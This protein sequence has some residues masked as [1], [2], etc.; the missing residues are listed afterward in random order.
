MAC[1]LSHVWLEEVFEDKNL[2][3]RETYLGDLSPGHTAYRW[4]KLMTMALSFHV[5]GAE[6]LP[7]SVV[8]VLPQ[9]IVSTCTDG[10]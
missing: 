2:G 1:P 10:L 5:W 6:V 7:G 3:L 8:R 9:Q 4:E